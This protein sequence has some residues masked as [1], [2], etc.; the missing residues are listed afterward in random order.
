MTPTCCFTP[1]AVYTDYTAPTEE[2]LISY[3]PLV[4]KADV[5]LEVD[6]PTKRISDAA[7]ISSQEIVRSNR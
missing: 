3:I 4:K 5:A 1:F 7:D 2:D 6:R